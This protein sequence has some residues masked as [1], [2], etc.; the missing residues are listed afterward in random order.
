ML[1]CS[2]VLRPRNV[3]LVADIAE[4]AGALDV[5]DL[6]TLFA[7]LTDNPGDAKDILDGFVGSPLIE[8]A[9]AADT[10]TAALTYRIAILEDTTARS[11]DLALI[12]PK[13]VV[14][15]TMVEAATA[16]AAQDATGAAGLVPRSAMVGSVFVNSD[17]TARQAN[18][19]GIMV[20]L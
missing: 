19:D 20:N 6:V 10:V 15:A 12:V 9:T 1:V 4:A 2:V 13:H 14:T 11:A 8:A 3:D 5:P 7:S 16:T 18:A 17:G